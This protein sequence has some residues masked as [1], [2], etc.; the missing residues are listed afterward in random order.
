MSG[1]LYVRFHISAV[2]L[3]A[4]PL[5]MTCAVKL[6]AASVRLSKRFSRNA[7]QRMLGIEEVTLDP[8][9]SAK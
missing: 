9:C 2:V 6:C 1:C 3:S 8:T 7:Q 4:A 5:Y